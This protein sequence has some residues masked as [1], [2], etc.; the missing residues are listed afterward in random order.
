[1]DENFDLNKLVDEVVENL[2]P[3]SSHKIIKRGGKPKIIFADPKYISR[4]IS[5]M[6]INAIKYSPGKDEIIVK[7]AGAKDSVTVSVQDY[8]R[9]IEKGKEQRI[10]EPYFRVET[11][12]VEK[13]SGLGL[14]LYIAREIASHYK[15]KIWVN[16]KIGQGS[17]FYFQMPC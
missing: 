2:N 8:G 1:M 3:A 7:V 4:I 5:N 12:K 14:G 15:G 13:I 17:T 16:T 11:K 10:F 9:G 6:I